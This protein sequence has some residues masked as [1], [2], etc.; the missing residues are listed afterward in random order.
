MKIKNVSIKERLSKSS[1][2]ESVTDSYFYK[3]IETTINKWLNLQKII[4]ESQSLE[5]IIEKQHKDN[6]E[7]MKKYIDEFYNLK[8]KARKLYEDIKFLKMKTEWVFLSSERE[9]YLTEASGTYFGNALTPIKNII[10]IIRE[11]YDYIPIL[12]SLIDEKDTKQDIESFAEFLC[13]Q[14][15]TNILIPNPEQEELLIC[16]FKLLEYEI[17]KMNFVDVEFFLDDSTFIGKLLTAFSKQQELNNF[18]VNLL[19]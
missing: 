1:Y 10:S 4:K 19:S 17:N 11:H 6:F 7:Q 2:S 8:L 9:Y 16:I 18:I 15:Y 3:N 5:K 12:I 14:F 13:N